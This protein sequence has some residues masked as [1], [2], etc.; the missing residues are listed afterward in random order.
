[1][2][3]KQPPPRTAVSVFAV[4]PA[5]AAERELLLIR[6]KAATAAKSVKVRFI[7]PYTSDPGPRIFPENTSHHG[8]YWIHGRNRTEF[9]FKI[10][11]HSVYSVVT[12]AFVDHFPF[13]I[14]STSYPSGASMKAIRD[15]LPVVVGPSLRAKP[16]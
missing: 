6:S 3:Q 4:L 7:L 15:P 11:L 2:H 13:W 5:G 16:F 12:P 9:F 8:K 10:I 14:S 1:M